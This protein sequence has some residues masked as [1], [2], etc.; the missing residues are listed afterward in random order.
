MCDSCAGDLNRPYQLL[1]DLESRLGGSRTPSTAKGGPAWPSHGVYFFF[2][3]AETRPNG[4]PRVVRVGT[5]ALTLTCRTSLW[6]R[7]SQHRGNL[8]GSNAGDGNHRGSIFCLHVGAALLRRD[9]AP[10][11][12]LESWLAKKTHPHWAAAERPNTRAT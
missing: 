12:L 5:H 6:Q 1:S 9:H 10:E 3:P 8:A 2:E 4:Q 11:A 7:M